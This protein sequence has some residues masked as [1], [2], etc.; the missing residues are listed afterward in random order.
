[1]S[2]GEKLESEDLGGLQVD[3]ELDFRD[4]GQECPHDASA[5]S[6]TLASSKSGVPKPSV[7]QP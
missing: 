3:E 6:R 2:E 7:N 4:H 5:S 1:M